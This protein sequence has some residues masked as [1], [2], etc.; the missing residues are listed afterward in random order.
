MAH[1]PDLLGNGLSCSFEFGP[2]R[3]EAGEA[4]LSKTLDELAL[5]KPTYV[6]ITYGAGGS[7]RDTAQLCRGE[8]GRANPGP[9]SADSDVQ[10][11]CKRFLHF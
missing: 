11:L 4:T 7:T 2:P 9:G 10:F 5:R 8:A 6:S 3:D 1:I